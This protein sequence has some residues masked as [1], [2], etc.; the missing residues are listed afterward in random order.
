MS[1]PNNNRFVILYH[2]IPAGEPVADDF[3][4]RQSHW[5][6]ML[7]DRDHLL[8]WAIEKQPKTGE[9]AIATQLADHR[10]AYL[11]YEGE[12]SDGRGNVT[13]FANGTFKWI[14]RTKERIVVEVECEGS[15]SRIELLRMHGD[16]TGA[17]K[18]ECRF[19]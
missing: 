13:Q 5:D 14:E 2:E 1:N 17:N 12:I 4:K 11:D 7:A 8:T 3:A 6:L 9:V 15:L 10:L 16:E 18:F 19:D